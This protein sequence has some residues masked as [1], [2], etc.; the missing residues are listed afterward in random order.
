MADITTVNKFETQKDKNI[1]VSLNYILFVLFLG[2]FMM[3]LDLFIFSPALVTIVTYFKTSYN[4]VTWTIM[5]YVL[6]TTAIMPVSGKLADIFGRKKIYIIGISLFTIGS[7]LCSLSWD[8]Y[9]LVVFRSIQAIGG[10][11][12]V[13]TALS[14]MS[15]Y[16]PKDKQGKTLGVLI[17]GSSLASIVGPNVGGYLIENFGWRSIFYIN[18]PIGIITILLALKFKE[19]SS[20]QKIHI[21][22]I[23][24]LLLIGSIGSM[25]L[26]LIGIETMPFTNINVFPYFLL[27]IILLVILIYWES[28][29]VE[30]ILNIPLLSQ[31]RI[32]ALNIGFLLTFA[33]STTVIIFIPTFVQL[34]LSL[35]IAVS[36]SILTPIS[37]AVLIMS[38]I[39]GILADKY[40]TKLLLIASTL[41]NALGFFLLTNSANNYLSL[42]L[43]LIIIGAGVGMASSAFPVALFAIV[44]EEEKGTSVAVLKTF[45]GIGT[46][47]API[48]GG[49]YL[50]NAANHA[51]TINS[52]FNTIFYISF[53]LLI[54]TGIILVAI[55][56]IP[57]R[58]PIQ[59]NPDLSTNL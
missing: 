54:L 35:G 27:A 53:L 39:G 26:G 9:S 23:G 18:I 29:T 4:W 43:I 19:N 3:G 22:I 44:P 7:F 58:N 51:I 40:G 25:V 14:A 10:G 6:I 33:A 1:N 37:V 5:I 55:F 13:P 16:A 50:T 12:I 17:A 11:I 52:A 32:L 8:I 24:S 31:G 2:V 15:V 38:I 30:P 56:I 47:L 28:N 59:D 57:K 20:S 41:I 34:V 21:D 45:S 42:I 36:G 48:I 46:I 49:Y